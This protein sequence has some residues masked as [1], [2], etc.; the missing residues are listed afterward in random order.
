M[1][2][3][4]GHPANLLYLPHWDYR[5][6]LKGLSGIYLNTA[7]RNL[8]FGI[9]GIFI[10]IY[11]YQ[12]TH[13]IT[14][15]FLFYLIHRIATL[16]SVYPT[17]KLIHKVGPDISMLMSSFLAAIYLTLLSMLANAP[18][19]IW[20]TAVFGGIKLGLHWLPY[21][22]AF[23]DVVKEESLPNDLTN[24]SNL[25]RLIKTLAPLV[26]G[27]VAVQLGFP[28]LLLMGVLLLVISSLP[29]F[30]DEYN[31][32]EKV[33]PLKKLL[34]NQFTLENESLNLS[35]FFQGFR[36]AIDGAIWPLILYSVIPS[37]EKIGGI[38]TITLFISFVTMHWLG[39][40]LKHFKIQPLVS[41]N[42]ARSFI[43]LVRAITSHPLI[44]ALTDPFYQ[45]ASLFVNIPRSILI[46]Q[47]GKRKKLNFFTQRE[48]AISLGR[49]AS[50]GLVYVI[51][52]VGFPWKLI[53]LLPIASITL[54]N[55][56]LYQFSK[57]QKSLLKKFRIKLS[58]L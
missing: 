37:F 10:P 48:L 42:V 56:Y 7:I 21:H 36:L 54:G 13:S 1:P 44:I 45:F 35:F 19:L 27:I 50:L 57:T 39:N 49:V 18:E 5:P 20:L 30:L 22:T 8:A 25:T 6:E 11:I 47:L 40:K 34:K 29:V 46:Y 32:K 17:A 28:T 58:R 43:W 23:A 31:K 4:N 41:G 24:V 38:T 33:L 26:G 16:V 15:V 52:K 12:V 55:F 14:D 3:G 2:N 9:L 53:P 51:L